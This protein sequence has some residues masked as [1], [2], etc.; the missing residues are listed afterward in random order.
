MQL[1]KLEADPNILGKRRVWLL[2]ITEQIVCKLVSIV[3]T[4]S[5]ARDNNF[6]V[7]HDEVT[8]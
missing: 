3:T 6:R 1:V 4:P 2:R 8:L 5:Q 7:A